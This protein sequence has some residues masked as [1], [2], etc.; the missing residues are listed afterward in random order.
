MNKCVIYS[1]N[2]VRCS[3]HFPQVV[4]NAAST[5]AGSH[6]PEIGHSAGITLLY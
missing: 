4:L 5:A 1:L 2:A 3:I 6:T